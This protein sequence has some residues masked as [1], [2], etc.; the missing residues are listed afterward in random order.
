[1]TEKPRLLYWGILVGV[2]T[3]LAYVSRI[4]AGK[5]PADTLYRYDTA[6]ETFV[7]DGIIIAIV[8]AIAARRFDLLALRRPPSWPRALGLAFAAALVI[9]FVIGTLDQ[10]VHA[11][12]EQGLTPTRWDPHRAGAYV[13]N[14]VFLS[15]FVPFAEELL[16]RGLG[17]SL[18]AR[19]GRRFAIVAVGVT[20]G[21]THGLFLGL[22]VLAAFGS[23]LAWVRAKTGSIY[24]GMI[25]HGTYNALAL[26]AAVTT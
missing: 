23:V 14:L 16:F 10:I 9:L 18:L 22:P 21:L 12:E 17:Y 13:V 8:V 5:P 24:P 4:A 19:F 20:F 6:I 1:M 7:V 2:L 25:V 3:T 15:S 26:I 11:G